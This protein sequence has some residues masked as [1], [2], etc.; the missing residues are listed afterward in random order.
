VPAKTRSW[1][2][3]LRPKLR[4]NFIHEENMKSIRALIANCFFVL[5]F[6]TAAGAQMPGMQQGPQLRGLFN[7]VVGSGAQYQVQRGA[8]DANKMTMEVD[9][10]GKESADGKDGFW[11]E[12]TA[13][14]P[15]GEMI[16]KMLTVSDGPN[17]SVAKMIMQMKGGQ[18]MEMPAQM[19]RMGQQNQSVDIRDKADDL[20]T[21]S[22]TVPAGT[23][24]THHYRLKDGSGDFW[25]SEQVSP[26]GLIK[27]EGKDFSMVLLKAVTDAKD[28][29]T[30]T[31]VPFNPALMM[32]NA[33]R[34]AGRPQPQQ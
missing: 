24:S 19:G 23:F 28:K 31:P 14:T 5:L 32:Q 12:V 8:S 3:E 33:T 18:P 7:P 25:L 2:R 34:G 11:L 21:E 29:I 9:V 16:M 6:A 17:I 27:G 10:V 20:G 4:L 15:M 13:A 1:Q 30:G 26:Y 22:V